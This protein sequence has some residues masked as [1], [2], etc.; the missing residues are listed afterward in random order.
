MT[1]IT[2][3][4]REAGYRNEIGEIVDATLQAASA[5][6]KPLPAKSEKTKLSAIHAAIDAGGSLDAK[7]KG[8]ILRQLA[9]AD[10]V[11]DDLG[12]SAIAAISAGAQKVHT[13][14]TLKAASEVPADKA[15]L[16][17]VMAQARRYNVRIREDEIIDPLDLDRQLKSG[18]ATLPQRF[19]FKS[20]LF[21]LRLLA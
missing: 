11:V 16:T 15:L 6:N 8:E 2:R 12:P 17:R 4:L 20:A 19:E 13:L 9:K 14:R 7:S 1:D 5:A 21:Q 10:L 18:N 3:L